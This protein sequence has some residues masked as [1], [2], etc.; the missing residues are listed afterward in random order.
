MSAQQGVSDLAP[1]STQRLA[2][3]E[4]EAAHFRHEA[5]KF[6][7]AAKHGISEEDVALLL[8]ATDEDTLIRQAQG[9]VDMA[10]QRI[11]VGGPYVARE[12]RH[13]GSPRPSKDQAM[14]E[15]VRDLFGR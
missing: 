6:K 15:V 14:R 11:P 12:G 9:L 1:E 10:A 8:T 5:L 4:A 7:V 2:S 13:P 3:A